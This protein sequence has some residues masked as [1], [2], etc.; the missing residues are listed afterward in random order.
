MRKDTQ[1]P[2]KFNIFRLE[3]VLFEVFRRWGMHIRVLVER[4]KNARKS[5]EIS[6]HG[7]TGGK[8]I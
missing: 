5:G 1:N 3:G 7:I 2:P 8:L 6:G 4:I